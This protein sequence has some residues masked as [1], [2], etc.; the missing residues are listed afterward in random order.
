MPRK[1]L[2]FHKEASFPKMTK[3][4]HCPW[5]RCRAGSC[6]VHLTQPHPL[7]RRTVL[8]PRATWCC[9]VALMFSLKPGSPGLHA[10]T[11]RASL[12]D[13]GCGHVTF[14]QPW[15]SACRQFPQ[16]LRLRDAARARRRAPPGTGRTGA[17]QNPRGGRGQAG[18][19]PPSPDADWPGGVS[20]ATGG[21]RPRPLGG[22]CPRRAAGLGPHR[23]WG[24]LRPL[25][26]HGHGGEGP[27]ENR[28]P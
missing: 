11:P 20:T 6:P 1:T 7:P 9:L 17:R 3:T 27:G 15:G 14:A 28:H 10:R 21:A 12:C 22:S 2:L 18:G 23:G 16:T 4:V 8:P 24:R 26:P 13:T 5:Q 25:R 19:A